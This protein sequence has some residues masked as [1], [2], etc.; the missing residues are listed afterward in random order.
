MSLISAI[1]PIS[2]M[3]GKLD[4][5]RSWVEESHAYDMQVILV[6]DYKDLETRIEL[7]QI[8]REHKDPRL[9]FVQG[10]FGNPGKARNVGLE[11]A[12]GDWVAFWDSDDLPKLKNIFCQIK[13]NNQDADVLIGRYQKFHILT[14]TSCIPEGSEPN[15]LSVALN[16]GIWRMI[17]KR[18]SIIE[19]R[20][21]SLR[22]G[23]DQAF[24]SSIRLADLSIKFCSEIFYQYNIGNSFQLT[25]S[26]DALD[27]LPKATKM[28]LR[29]SLQSSKALRHFQLKLVAR[30]QLTLL[31]KSHGFGKFQAIATLF[32]L[33]FSEFLKLTPELI[34]AHFVIQKAVV[35]KRFR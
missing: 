10:K 33:K 31:H 32:T 27:D 9:Q 34:N 5:L 21:P 15:I 28:I 7:E 6:H 22:M 17:F 13:E 8:L 26:K 20:F 12:T 35:S 3:A 1:V 2:N 23:E 25:N 24:L 30:Q 18:A 29:Q 19:S 16:P 14:H 11:L 4:F